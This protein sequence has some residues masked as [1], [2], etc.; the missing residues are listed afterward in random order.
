MCEKLDRTNAD[1]LLPVADVYYWWIGPTENFELARIVDETLRARGHSAR[2]FFPFDHEGISGLDRAGE[3]LNALRGPRFGCTGTVQRLFFDET[4]LVRQRFR[5]GLDCPSI[6]RPI[7]YGDPFVGRHG[8]Y[9]IF[10]MLSFEAGVRR[11]D[12]PSSKCDKVAS[13]VSSP[14]AG[15]AQ[16]AK[17]SIGAF[18]R[19]TAAHLNPHARHRFARQKEDEWNEASTKK[20]R[21]RSGVH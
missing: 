8:F 19:T 4:Q 6:Q 5:G 13:S 1:R 17:L 11:E 2:V 3:Q 21:A 16:G 18:T 7:D 14:P 9:G 20:A 15:K 12:H 10:S